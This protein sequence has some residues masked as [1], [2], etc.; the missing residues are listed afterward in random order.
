MKTARHGSIQNA[1]G[2]RRRRVAGLASAGFAATLMLS[3]GAPAEAQSPA[4]TAR[5]NGSGATPD[6]RP[7]SGNGYLGKRSVAVDGS[8]NVYVTGSSNV[9]GN[10]EYLTV[11][12]SSSGAER[13]ASSKNGPGN[14]TDEAY[15]VARDASGNIYV[16]GRSFNGA[17]LDFMTVSYD[18]SGAERW[19]KIKNGSANNHDWAY[20]VAVDSAGNVYVSGRSSNGS[21]YDFLTVSYDSVGNERWAR[22]KNGGANRE[23]VVFAIAMG[24]NDNLVVTGA[25]NNAA[26]DD[27]LT[28]AYDSNG[29][30]RWARSKNG[31]GN[32]T[33]QAYDVTVDGSGNVFVTGYSSNGANYDFLTVSYDT[34]GTERWARVKNGSGNSADQANAVAVDGGGN[35]YVTGSASNGANADFLTVSY[36]TAGTERWTRVKNG[37]GNGNDWGYNVLVDS[38]GQAYVVGSSPNAS[39]ND[40]LVVAYDAAGTELW[41]HV[42]DAG[43]QD[44]AYGLAK[45]PGSG[46]VVTGFSTAGSTGYLTMA[47]G[48][49]DSTPP[50]DPT[51]T[52]TIPSPGFWSNDNTVGVTWSGAA[53][54]PGG[55]GLAGYSISWDHTSG[56][57]PDAIVDVPHGVD[58]HSTTSAALLP[59]GNDWYFHLRTCDNAGNCTATVHAGPFW[60]DTTAPGTVGG[61]HST[62]HWIGVPRPTTQLDLAFAASTDGLSGVDGYAVAVDSSPTW[63][64]DGTKDLEESTLS[65]FEVVVA[66]T[67]YAH[68]CALDNAGNAGAVATSGPYVVGPQGSDP[69]IY[70]TSYGSGMVG[71][72]SADGSSVNVLVSV[73][74]GALGVQVD[75]AGGDLYWAET[76]S[77]Q[78][79]RG[80]LDGSGPV[81]LVSYYRPRNLALDLV[82]G[83]IYW[84][85]ELSNQITRANLDGSGQIDYLPSPGNN[86]WGLALDLAGGKIYWSEYSGQIRRGNLDGTGIESLTASAGT[87]VGL[88]LDRPRGKVYWAEEQDGTIHRAN[89][90]G[91]GHAV[92][93]T[94]ESGVRG[95]EIDEVNQKIFW[96][97]PSQIRRSNLDGSS[98]AT[99]FSTPGTWPHA[100]ALLPGDAFA[101]TDPAID[102][103]SPLATAWSND[104]TVD[105][106]W[107]G[108]SD[109]AGGSGLDG[110]SVEWN[111]TA[112]S[113]PDVTVDVPHTVDPHSTTSAALA[114]GNDS[115]FHLRTCDKAGNCTATV[116][117]GP[118]W[119]DTTAPSAPGG[120]TSSSH[121][122]GL[123]QADATVD[124][125]WGAASDALS[126]IDGYGVSFDQSASSLCEPTKDVEETTTSATSPPLADGLWYAHV[127]AVDNGGTW[128]AVAHGGPFVI[129]STGLQPA[130]FWSTF[131]NSRL[132]YGPV[133]GPA[134]TLHQSPTVVGPSGLAVDATT[135]QIYWVD[136]GGDRI[137]RSSIDGTGVVN[138]QTGFSYPRDVALDLAGGK[139]YWTV[140]EGNTVRR[141]NLDG[142]S[143]EVLVTVATPF[144]LDLDLVAGYLYFANHPQ[145]KV[146]RITLDGTGL[147]D[148]LNAPNALGVAVDRAA[149]KIYWSEARGG[150]NGLL[151]RANLDGSNAETLVAG[152]AFPSDLALDLVNG[153]IYWAEYDAGR[154]GRARLD[155]TQQETALLTPGAPDGVALLPGDAQAPSDPAI[156]TTT[157]PASVWANDNTVEAT[158]SG[159]ADNLGGSGLEGYSVEWNHVAL[160][161]PDA[162]VDIAHTTDP[163]ATTSA[164]LAD[165]NDWYFHLR[166]CDLAGNCTAG[167]HAGPYWIDT[168]S[169]SAPGAVIST[170]HG[171]GLPKSD[172]TVEISWGAAS[173]GLSGVAVYRYGFTATATP[174]A[175][176]GLGTTTATLAGGSGNLADG[177]W[178]AHVC[179]VDG[180]GNPGAV[181]A[182]GP[183]VVDTTAPTGLL[184]TS[185]SH[186]VSTWSSDASIEF[187]FSGAADASGVSGYAVVFDT[188]VGTVPACAATQAGQSFTGT[189]SPDGSGWQLHVR[190]I[191]AAGNCGETVAFGPFWIDTTAPPAPG[192]VVSPSHDGGAT[193]DPTIDVEWGPSSARAGAPITGYRFDFWSGAVSPACSALIGNSTGTSASSAVLSEGVWYLSV[194]AIDGAG[195][196]ST[197]TTGGPYTIDTSGPTGL[198]VASTS[199]ALA[200]W[201]SDGDVDFAFSG[202]IDPNGVAGYSIAFDQA[203]ATVPD[204]TP[205][206][207]G[208]TFTGTASPDGSD[209]YLHVRAC[210]IAGNCSVSAHAGPYWIDTGAPSATGPLT[211][212]SHGDGEPHSDP[213]VAIAWGVASD[214]LSG[215]GYYRYDFTALAGAPACA[216]LV[217]TTPELTAVS[218]SLA[219]G[220]WYA[221]ACAVDTAGNRGAVVSG[222]P[223]RID[224][225]PPT[226][227]AFDSVART[228]DLALT[229][230]EVVG[231]PLTQIY[232]SFTE[233]M[234]DPPGDATPGDVTN[235]TG[236]LLVA[237]G[238]DGI[239][240]T[241]GCTVAGDDVAVPLAITWSAATRT[242][243]LAPG[244]GHAL[245]GDSYLVAACGSLLDPA[246]NPLDGDGNGTGGDAGA[247]TFAVRGTD[248]AGNPNF[249]TGL[250]GWTVVATVPGEVAT[251]LDD[252]GEQPTSG[253]VAV[254]STAGAG[255]TWRLEQCVTLP[256]HGWSRLSGRL[257]SASAVP[258]APVAHLE[259]RYFGAVDCSSGALAT[260][261]TPAVAG[262]T[263]PAWVAVSGGG[264]PFPAGAHSANVRLIVVA[265][266]TNDV[267]LR[268]DELF[269]GDDGLLFA[270]GFES[271][272]TDSWSSAVP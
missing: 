246:G 183:Y 209:W 144:C 139:V 5:K 31:A 233:E 248:L 10:S 241:V 12:Y 171:D 135:A 215:V 11:S 261:V 108:A 28:V 217:A 65:Y 210:D 127:C 47:F 107:S 115:Y 27:Y 267:D 224:T 117:A 25:S 20:A 206:Q 67:W 205:E 268:A 250:A 66:G 197:V 72:A 120:V 42:F 245:A 130:V 201:S 18:S 153:W 167:V 7:G 13:W 95:I 162:T 202:A 189:A 38:G 203:A 89:L 106:A 124:I 80:A 168:A 230:G 35:V 14:S 213:T 258:G 30:E 123:P 177:I 112:Q 9:G 76:G 165:G 54:N 97:T 242:A 36:D 3:G 34:L 58:P 216:T 82:H 100:V 75:R 192:T 263:G 57:T 256:A 50:S 232:A 211:S 70:W 102:S 234:F 6:A 137:R 229:E 257:R 93:V 116:H 253:S 109:N 63:T 91:S 251:D 220:T 196:E 96:T 114:D 52:S 174:P 132:G 266:A 222:G 163:H 77:N 129:D 264:A 111:H 161:T 104:V 218:G 39:N 23:D 55:L 271:G 110:Y 231:Q 131:N 193:S 235:P 126:G 51:L 62:S 125:A 69:V 4:W 239:V 173:D 43:S 169:P 142:T 252:A 45:R 247:R 79:R 154:I 143:P 204:S 160:A 176:S 148:V 238:P 64:C 128:G 41:A 19:T 145:G 101:P 44:S 85:A 92:V 223:Y 61:L 208:T 84:T 149:G 179:A 138:V 186:T 227:E 185:S 59:G 164:P 60:I 140:L 40:Y 118:F 219:D 175:C 262:D 87:R 228:P 21:N 53:D 81:S 56:T 198:V 94:G 187:G 74:G 99:V 199:H 136:W 105:V 33:D 190:A 2:W 269:F 133:G 184:V 166:T 49:V 156:G 90:D 254:T 259:A 26:N 98:A 172:P 121:A 157:P 243:H 46:L 32:S 236:W 214:P 255:E 37:S 88:A 119:I 207:A 212:A 103:T 48:P 180:A 86:P 71:N 1:G 68:V 22:V 141:A 272:D 113:T 158:W 195:N 147:T 244:G 73:P 270:D 240:D 200:T 8:G 155:G 188:A 249:D 181:I 83:Y 150:P 152:L 17:N 78:I 194:C 191:D 226:V 221:H 146:Q 260:I 225:A 29:N 159:A 16:T 237:S 151:R 178:Y 265:G 122:L 134:I 182:G 170:S 15:A 24:A